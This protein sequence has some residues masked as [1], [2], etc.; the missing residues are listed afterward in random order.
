MRF[1]YFRPEV[2]NK[3][4]LNILAEFDRDPPIVV[5]SLSEQSRRTA[6]PTKNGVIEYVESENPSGVRCVPRTAIL[7]AQIAQELR[8][9]IS[10]VIGS[11]VEG[12]HGTLTNKEKEKIRAPD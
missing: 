6:I 9:M 4:N 5:G 2:F 10:S 3:R 12:F 11:P 8:L 7:L 1:Y